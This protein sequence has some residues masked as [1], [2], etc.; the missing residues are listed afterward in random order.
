[1]EV[2]AAKIGEPTGV[3]NT[4]DTL[5][6]LRVSKSQ[7]LNVELS[8]AQSVRTIISRLHRETD[9]RFKTT[10]TPTG[11]LVWRLK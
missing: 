1:M 11:I 7:A 9:F 6:R 10:K 3:I 4:T 8:D 2:V 5:K